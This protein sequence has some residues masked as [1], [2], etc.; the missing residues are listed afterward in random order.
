MAGCLYFVYSNNTFTFGYIAHS[1]SF[2]SDHITSCCDYLGLFEF[3][4]DA[5]FE[6][7]CTVDDYTNCDCVGCDL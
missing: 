6:C 7:C 3:Y 1:E 5:M 4:K 2:P